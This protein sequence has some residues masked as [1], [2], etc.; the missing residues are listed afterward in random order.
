MYPIRHRPGNGLTSAE[1][2][3]RKK[4]RHIVRLLL[5]LEFYHVVFLSEDGVLKNRFC[6]VEEERMVFHTGAVMSQNQ[7]AGMSQSS[8]FCCISSRGVLHLFATLFR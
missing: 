7:F 8:N 1:L 3:H 5:P 6:F 4:N 2:L